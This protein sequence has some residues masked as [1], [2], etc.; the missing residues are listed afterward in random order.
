MKK[1]GD[2]GHSG[3][4]VFSFLEKLFEL[5]GDSSVSFFQFFIDHS[6]LLKS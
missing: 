2:S 4:L 3:N 1:G 5:P 6:R